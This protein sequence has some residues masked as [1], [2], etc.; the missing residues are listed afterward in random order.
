MKM[1]HFKQ[2]L[3]SKSIIFY[4]NFIK[5]GHIVKYRDVFFKFDNGPYRNMLQQ[6]WPF[7]YENSLLK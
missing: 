1:Y 4:Q 6:L 3:L 2:C 5:L 7:V